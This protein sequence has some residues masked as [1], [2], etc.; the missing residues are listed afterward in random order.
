[1]VAIIFIIFD[2]E[3]ATVFPTMTLYKEAAQSG[4][5]GLVFAKVFLFV[6]LLLVGLIYAWS[7]GDLEWVKGVSS[8]GKNQHG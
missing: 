3:I 1:M 6:A 4:H 5:A 7:R 2:V 8:G